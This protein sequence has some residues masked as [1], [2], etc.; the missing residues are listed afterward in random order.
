MRPNR[1]EYDA[2]VVGGGHNG[3]V[4]SFY[5]AR[6]GLRVLVV[7]RRRIV[8]GLAGPLEFF[9]G[10]R[11]SLTN[12]PSALEPVV[13]K[14]MELS[15]FGLE[16]DRPDPTMVFPLEG[17]D[18]FVAWRDRAAVRN[19]IARIAPDDVDSYFGVLSFFDEFAKTIG[20]SVREAPPSLSQIAARLTTPEAEAAFNEIFFD[21]IGDFLDR[22]IRS[23]HIKALLASLAMSAGNVA[24]STPG[25]PLG[26][27]RRP[28]SA[29]GADASIED[30]RRSAT[31]GSTGLPRGGMGSITEAM[32]RSA[33]ARGV[34]IMTS[35][36]VH[37]ILTRSGAV[38]GIVTD[39]GDEIRSTL[40]LSNLNPKTTLLD[41]LGPD[42]VPARIGDQLGALSMAGG[43]YK[44]VLA[45]DG[46][47][48]H[49]SA[50]DQ[51]D[52]LRRASCQ[53]RY[54][55]TVDYLERAHED[56]KHGR[57]SRRPKMLGLTPSIS[58]PS[59]A[60]EGR[61]L[62]TVSVWFA[63][64]ELATGEWTDADKD[65]FNLICLDTMEEFIPNIRDVTTDVLGLSPRD[66]ELEYGLVGGH[67]LHGDMTPLGFF[68]RPVPAL[69]DYRT[70]VRG[71]YLCGAGTW[72]GGTVTGLPGH[73]AAHT[74]LGDQVSRVDADAE[75][76]VPS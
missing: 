8:G 53:Y 31:R 41:L 71:L 62:M 37:S 2:I 23:P 56:Y 45:M 17:G 54:S 70:P 67:Q 69:R 24:P 39:K 63:P 64:H 25:S 44:L 48:V 19:E 43:A 20:V 14:D 5:L 74:A 65:A 13:A 6:A 34:E 66:L 10:Y 12:T 75:A 52:A 30:P 29:V 1:T 49:A 3:L 61:Q 57:V 7:E 21:S 27:L 72:P 4:A 73:N 58:D 42:D 26:L 32:E 40:V 15:A 36:G 55:P 46:I 76:G 35:T 9:P 28:L 22:R 11:G 59:L 60:P 47:P 33:L 38:T 50:T 16:Y 51:E 18:A 68:S